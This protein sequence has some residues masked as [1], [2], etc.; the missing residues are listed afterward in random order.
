MNI[1]RFAKL[2]GGM[3][4]VGSVVTTQ[5]AISTECAMI[6]SVALVKTGV[7]FVYEFTHRRIIG[8]PPCNSMRDPRPLLGQVPLAKERRMVALV[9]RNDV[10][11][12]A[13]AHLLS[14]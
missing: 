3:P 10:Q 12:C 9:P 8:I 6:L 1:G 13:H 5:T 2:S 11:K 4:A 14:V 7:A